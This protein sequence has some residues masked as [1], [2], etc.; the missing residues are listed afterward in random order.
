MSENTAS[1]NQKR[2]I[3]ALTANLAIIILEIL[4]FRISIQR[5][6]ISLFQY[7][8]QD[9]NILALIASI[10]CAGYSIR[11]LRHGGVLPLWVK[12]LKYMAVSCLMVTLVVVLTILAPTTG[13][14]GFKVMF[15]HHS[16]LYHH[17][18]CPVLALLSFIFLDTDPP[19]TR[20]HIRYALLP[21]LLYAVVVIIL[22]V[23]KV[24]DGPYPFLRIYGQPAYM[25]ALWCLLILGG[26]YLLAWLIQ[27]ANTA[28]ANHLRGKTA[29]PVS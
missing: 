18:L 8:T 19:L 4:G 15:F 9:S 25:S 5:S 28:Y 12:V 13:E 23:L 22:N 27:L 20:K 17:L 16:M 11:S 3:A 21:T 7:Y 29:E 10:F 24:L 6:G 2:Q 1:V 14:N 26:A